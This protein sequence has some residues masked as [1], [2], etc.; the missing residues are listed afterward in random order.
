MARERDHVAEP[1]GIATV[2]GKMP[3][4]D[5]VRLERCNALLTLGFY[6]GR[7]KGHDGSHSVH[8]FDTDRVYVWPRTEGDD[9]A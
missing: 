2:G 6:C 1:A 3:G 4:T 9:A 7:E 8:V 5:A